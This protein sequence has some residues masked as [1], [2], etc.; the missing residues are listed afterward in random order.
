MSAVKTGL[1]LRTLALTPERIP[2][3]LVPSRGRFLASPRLRR[4]S[5]DRTRLLSDSDST[6]AS[7]PV[8]PTGLMATSPRLLRTPTPRLGRLRRAAATT[9]DNTDATVQAAM[10]QVHVPKVTTPYGFRAVLAT[11]PCTNGTLFHRSKPV[12][13]TVTDAG[14]QDPETPHSPGPDGSRASIRPIKSLGLQVMKELKKPVAALKALSPSY[15]ITSP[16]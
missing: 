16:R 3:F 1:S 14:A 10:S 12:K 11:S 9:E 7:P 2:S 8:T 5:T 4:C 13:V 6:D 15:R